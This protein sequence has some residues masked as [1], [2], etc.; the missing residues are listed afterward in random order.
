M[1]RAALCLAG[2]SVISC[3]IFHIFGSIATSV[4]GAVSWTAAA[5][6]FILR[7]HI[8]SGKLVSFV[9]LISSVF[10][11][12]LCIY[13]AI[14]IKPVA[15]LDGTSHDVNA[16]VISE[17]ESYGE[18]G[19]ITVKTTKPINAALKGTKLKLIIKTSDDVFNANIGD[20][21]SFSA[22]FRLDDSEYSKYSKSQNI[23]IS[24]YCKD[25]KVTGHKYT[26]LQTANKIKKYVQSV[27]NDN[28][29][30]DTAELINGVV[31]GADQNISQKLSE[32]FAACGVSHITSVSGMHISIVY[33]AVVSALSVVLSKRKATLFAALPMITLISITGFEAASLRA[34]IMSLFALTG[35]VALKRTDPLN[36]LGVAVFLLLVLNPF[37]ILDLGFCLSCSA[38]AGVIIALDIIKP[39]SSKIHFKYNILEKLTEATVT[40]IAISIG[41]AV[42][43]LPFQ[44]IIFE[45][46]SL[47]TPIAN[48]LISPAVTYMMLLT[49]VAVI[50]GLVPVIGIISKPIFMAAGLMSDYII[51]VISSLSK[52]P[53]SSIT[54]YSK[55]ALIWI[56]LS[57]ALIGL[58]LLLDRIGGIKFISVLIVALLIISI[59]SQVLTA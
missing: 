20:T 48:V 45:K 25:T 38:T 54:F 43:T 14:F 58:W 57:L 17:P 16:I 53:F 8:S 37:Y 7:H 3:I 32:A 36:S 56:A 50:L 47:I 39:F 34:V 22:D 11:A 46:I 44:I 23:Y 2:I 1:K 49:I 6:C 51:A 28:F 18:Y 12:Y 31:L 35:N 42:F 29:Y 9:L 15:A 55:N 5:V 24:V 40:V 52:I 30:G 13:D 19:A 21:V 41:A 10:C 26:I 59:W 27:I 4:M 33:S